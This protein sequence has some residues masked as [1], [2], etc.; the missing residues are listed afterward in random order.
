MDAAAAATRAPATVAPVRGPGPQAHHGPDAS[1]RAA[2][3]LLGAVLA[4]TAALLSAVP[5]GAAT[6][7][8]GR[9]GPYYVAVGASEAVGVQPVPHHPHGARTDQGYADDLTAME[10]R[11]WPGLRLVDF[12]CPGITAQ[13]ALDGVGACRYPSGSELS[14]AVRFIEAHPGEVVLVTVDFGF[15]DIWPCLA[16]H[17]V[18]ERCV[19]TAIGRVARAVPEILAELRAAGDRRLLIVGLQ[20]GDPYVADAHFGQVAF[21]DATVAV[22][23]RLN[24]VLSAAYARA[25]AVVAQVPDTGARAAAPDAV[26]TACAQTWMCTD[27]NIHPTPA[28]YR[29]IAGAIASAIARGRSRA[30]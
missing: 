22:F 16:Y 7:T 5:A 27:R 4:T 3:V 17:H 28:G 30:G 9:S 20:H 12:G 29:V 21:A 15:N 1:H 8:S 26:E 10:Q 19:S 13:G 2:R 25:G 11:R 24:D 23:D 18:D 14:T 6:R